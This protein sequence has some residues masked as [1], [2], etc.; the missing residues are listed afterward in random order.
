M[1]RAWR[2]ARL[3]QEA[4]SAPVTAQRAVTTAE[5]VVRRAWA[6]ELLRRRDH[7]EFSV[8]AAQEEREAA[9]RRLVAAQRDG[10]PSRISLAH[11]ALERALHVARASE[12]AR[13]LARHTLS[14][15]LDLLARVAK[16]RMVP[17]P[18]LPLEQDGSV[19]SAARRETPAPRA[20]QVPSEAGAPGRAPRWFRRLLPRRAIGLEQP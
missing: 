15:Q 3:A 2:R 11:A 17:A 1:L 13:D 19:I 18:V 16:E 5:A 9:C 7:A 12:L 20:G 10:D 6:E 8:H 14:A 4:T